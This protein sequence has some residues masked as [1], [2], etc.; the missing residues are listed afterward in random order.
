MEMDIN[1]V[2]GYRTMLNLTQQQMAN[3]LG[4]TS[5][6]YSNKERGQRSFTDNEKLK[7]KKLFQ[8]IDINLTIDDIF[9]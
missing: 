3:H 4:I 5:Q 2:S 7:I 6:T 9:F 1:K 8:K